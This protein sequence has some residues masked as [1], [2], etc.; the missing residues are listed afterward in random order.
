MM[1]HSMEVFPRNNG[2]TEYLKI[3]KSLFYNKI[4]GEGKIPAVEIEFWENTEFN[5]IKSLNLKED[6]NDKKK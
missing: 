5:K 3:G 6:K 1:S 2:N 4:A